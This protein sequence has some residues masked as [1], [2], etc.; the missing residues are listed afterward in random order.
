MAEEE[1]SG[2]GGV[3]WQRRKEVARR[4]RGKALGGGETARRRGEAVIETAEG[5]DVKT[6]E[7]GKRRLDG[8]PEGKVLRLEGGKGVE[9]SIGIWGKPVHDII[10]WLKPVL[11]SS[12]GQPLHI[13][14]LPVTDTAPPI[15]LGSCVC[16]LC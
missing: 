6:A 4:R 8:R 15:L 11:S 12:V 2:G 3:R 5:E 16:P 7:G 13:P 14:H 1:G 10:M 9:V